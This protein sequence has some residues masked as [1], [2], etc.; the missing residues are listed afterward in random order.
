MLLSIL[1]QGCICEGENESRESWHHF[2]F[3]LILLCCYCIMFLCK[4]LCMD[5]FIVACLLFDMS[6]EFVGSR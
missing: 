4:T 5:V 3:G 2:Y 6:S 1:N